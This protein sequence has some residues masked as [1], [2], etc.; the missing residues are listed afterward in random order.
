MALTFECSIEIAAPPQKVFAA[1][2]DLD[3]MGKW[4]PSLVRIE[5]LTQGPLAKGSQFRQTRK[6]LGHEATEQF[7]VTEFDPPRALGLYVDG[8]KGSSK[9][10]EYRFRHSVAAAPDGSVLTL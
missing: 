5:R 6:M 4:M 7:E 2:A 10:G 3:A 1:L 8:T 9:C